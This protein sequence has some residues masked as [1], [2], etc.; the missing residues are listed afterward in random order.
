MQRVP[1]RTPTK[2]DADSQDETYLN[3]L[4]AQRRLLNQITAAGLPTASFSGNQS[5][6]VRPFAAMGGELSHDRMNRSISGP[7]SHMFPYN[8]FSS[9]GPDRPMDSVL[10]A[11]YHL[12][13]SFEM[14]QNGIEMVNDEDVKV[15]KLPPSGPSLS[16]LDNSLS[17]RGSMA[18]HRD[19]DLYDQNSRSGGDHEEEEDVEYDLSS[20]EPLEFVDKQVS[21]FLVKELIS[22]DK[23]MAKSQESQQKIH[24]WDKKMGLK[25]SHSKTMRLSSRSRN[26]IRAL[27]KRELSSIS[28]QSSS[29]S[30]EAGS[31]I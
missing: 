15:T 16:F 9:S 19:V 25:R 3:L 7:P 8:K 29:E 14:K 4:S 24:D 28:E 1:G 11:P 12:L 23:A 18:S 21:A 31:T 5:L 27:L 13:P 6:D 17:R 20:I 30:R 22:L 26:K 10:A 2:S